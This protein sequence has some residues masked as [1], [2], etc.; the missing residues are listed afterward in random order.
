MTDE[1]IEI[2]NTIDRT[3]QTRDTV[4]AMKNLRVELIDEYTGEYVQLKQPFT[5][6]FVVFYR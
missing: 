6:K 4:N 5:L 2:T 3:Y 1:T